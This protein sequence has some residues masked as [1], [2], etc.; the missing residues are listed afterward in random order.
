MSAA[1]LAQ[2]LNS[3]GF[4]VCA[5]DIGFGR[6]FQVDVPSGRSSS[7]TP[8]PASVSSRALHHHTALSASYLGQQLCVMQPWRQ[9]LVGPPLA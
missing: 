3:G 9:Q 6:T 8:R 4:H 7:R 1:A 5:W 2:R